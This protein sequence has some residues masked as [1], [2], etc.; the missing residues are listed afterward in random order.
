MKIPPHMK[1]KEL[2]IIHKYR[3]DDLGGSIIS[4]HQIEV[5]IRSYDKDK[6]QISI[7]DPNGEPYYLVRIGWY[8]KILTNSPEYYFVADSNGDFKKTVIKHRQDLGSGDKVIINTAL[9][10]FRKQI[11]RSQ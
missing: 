2:P 10:K 5:E 6:N 4:S 8:T 11:R 1:K 9:R 7:A 3:Y